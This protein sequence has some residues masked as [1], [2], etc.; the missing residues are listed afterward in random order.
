MRLSNSV[1]VKIFLKFLNLRLWL[2]DL[3]FLYLGLEIT[4]LLTSLC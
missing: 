4:I 1:V 3:E 2:D